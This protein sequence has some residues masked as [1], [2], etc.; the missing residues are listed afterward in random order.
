MN[1]LV[2][3]RKNQTGYQSLV[4]WRLVGGVLPGREPVCDVISWKPVLFW[5]TGVLEGEGEGE[6]EAG[7][8]EWVGK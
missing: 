6:G 8:M 5:F 7:R 3:A 1:A 4:S 2:F